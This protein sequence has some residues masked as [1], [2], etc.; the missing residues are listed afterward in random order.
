LGH[1]GALRGGVSPHL[2]VAAGTRAACVPVRRALNL[3]T[4]APVETLKDG[5]DALFV[6]GDPLTFTN[7][8]Q[9][10]V[11][12][13]L[14]IAAQNPGMH[15]LGWYWRPAA[16][17]RG[18]RRTAIEIRSHR[19]SP[20]KPQWLQR[21]GSR[22]L[23]SRERVLCSEKHGL[24]RKDCRYDLRRNWNLVRLASHQR[25]GQFI[26]AYKP[27]NPIAVLLRSTKPRS[28]ARMD[29]KHQLVAFLKQVFQFS[30]R[31]FENAKFCLGDVSEVI[32]ADHYG[33]VF[34][35]EFKCEHAFGYDRRTNA[36]N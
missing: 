4:P 21:T 26:T 16:L 20:L 24:P 25:L 12:I 28:L 27:D 13:V 5:V 14:L 6:V 10:I 7:R 22:C 32:L 3:L 29:G 9:E 15:D 11:G 36:V 2:A 1:G 34:G 35:H 30:T 31:Y 17:N 18:R 8:G 33:T 19:Q 23:D